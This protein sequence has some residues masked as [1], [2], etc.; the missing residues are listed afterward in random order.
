M[1]KCIIMLLTA[2][3]TVSLAACGSAQN[4]AELNLEPLTPVMAEATP[5]PT[6]DAAS[7]GNAEQET[8]AAETDA[9]EPV[10]TAMLEAAQGCI[11]QPVEALYEAVGEPVSA[12]YGASCL[13]ENAE[14]GMLTY[15]GFSVWTVRTETEEIVHEVYPAD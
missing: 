10:D 8:E 2:A 4:E 12:Q 15:D 1:K 7:P 11:G 3:V 13:E 6:E 5:A 9:G 14:D